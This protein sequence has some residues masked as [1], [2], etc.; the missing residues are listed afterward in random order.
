MY[1]I[2]L[3]G[4]HEDAKGELRQTVAGSGVD[5]F[6]VVHGRSVLPFLNQI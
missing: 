2:C 6:I 3:Q 5:N 4:T 1:T